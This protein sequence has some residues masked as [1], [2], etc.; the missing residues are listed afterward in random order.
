[1]IPQEIYNIDR[2]YSKP[3]VD[4]VPSTIQR[5]GR[6]DTINLLDLAAN[7]GC[8]ICGRTIYSIRP[9]P[10]AKEDLLLVRGQVI[11]DWFFYDASKEQ[12]TI[13]EPLM[14]QALKRSYHLHRVNGS[15]YDDSGVVTD[16]E[17]KSRIQRS[18]S[19]IFEG[20][21]GRKTSKVFDALCNYCYEQPP[22]PRE[23]RVYTRGGGAIAF[24]P[25]PDQPG[26]FTFKA[27]YEPDAFTFNRLDVDFSPDAECPTFESYIKDL[28]Y[29]ED[30]DALQ[31]FCGYCL[32]PSTR[33]QTALFIK[34]NGGEGKSVLTGILCEIFKRSAV[35]DKLAALEES[36]FKTANLENK[37]LFIDD[38]INSELL[39]ETGTIKQIITASTPLTVEKKG[40]DAHEIQPYAKILCAGNTFIGAAFDRSDGLYRRLLLMECKP[41]PADR[42]SDRFLIDKIREEKAGIFNWMLFG[43]LR[44]MN[45]GFEFTRSLRSRHLL[46]QKKTDDDPV[47]CFLRD[48]SWVLYQEGYITP[49]TDLYSAFLLWCSANAVEPLSMRSAMRGIKQYLDKLQAVTYSENFIFDGQRKRGY[50]GIGLTLS[51]I[52]QIRENEP[53]NLYKVK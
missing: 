33:A 21:I 11:P 48:D 7:S 5:D 36:R 53:K 47:S 51:A 34:G 10:Y 4:I 38:D 45:N 13:R 40:R 18:I 42:V 19:I 41:I 6:I 44:L 26:E 23:D 9:Q 2:T 17:V 1:M 46:E 8:V 43:L 3:F 29:P 39:K 49:S 20:D 35:V 25:K 28:V 31:E 15:F 37:L 32:I 30:M 52:A 24:E 12:F 27:V 22:R 50:S 16:A 14:C